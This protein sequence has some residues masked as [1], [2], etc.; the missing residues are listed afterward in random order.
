MPFLVVGVFSGRALAG[1]LAGGMSY[2]WPSS[3]YDCGGYFL[4]A[5]GCPVQGFGWPLLPSYPP[6]VYGYGGHQSSHA[7]CDVSSAWYGQQMHSFHG[8]SIAHP[9]YGQQMRSFS[10]PSS[11]PPPPAWYGQQMHPWYGQQMRSFSAPSSSPPPP[12]PR[13]PPPLPPPLLSPPRA[14]CSTHCPSVS[15]QPA[16]RTGESQVPVVDPVQGKGTVVV[17]K[18]VPAAMVIQPNALPQIFMYDLEKLCNDMEGLVNLD[19][20]LWG[21]GCTEV[22]ERIMYDQGL[23][24]L[25]KG[26]SDMMV[27]LRFVRACKS[28]LRQ[29]EL[30]QQIA[31]SARVEDLVG[32][33]V[34]GLM[35]TKCSQGSTDMQG[36]KS[37]TST[38]GSTDTFKSV[39]QT[40]KGWSKVETA[41]TWMQTKGAS[42]WKRKGT[43]E[44]DGTQEP[45]K[46][47]RDQCSGM[48]ANAVVVKC[49]PPE[50]KTPSS[51]VNAM[52]AGPDSSV[53]G[54]P[55]RGRGA[56]TESKTE[57]TQKPVKHIWDRK[58]SGT[59]ANC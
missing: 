12:P 22:Y 25:L 20:R 28:C 9:R 35:N 31:L 57:R 42:D 10:E 43:Q 16:T 45:R 1:C 39:D 26:T 59:G 29:F 17:P 18:A 8:P 19:S 54:F 52:S 53:R 36:T 15:A 50:D 55:G 34:K 47:T 33:S 46:T 56:A 51:W 13:P 24:T 11:S 14:P 7:G 37:C 30:L 48:A 41:S 23:E 4:R 5:P 2:C 6:H 49:Q 3:Y 32:K 40:G 38:K 44:G 58:C 21:D 27:K